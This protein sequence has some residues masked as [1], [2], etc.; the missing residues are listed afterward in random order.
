M[1]RKTVIESDEVS[2][3]KR[4]KQRLTLDSH[5]QKDW[6]LNWGFLVPEGLADE[7]E[8]VRG[9]SA[10]DRL[11]C[12]LDTHKAPKSKYPRAVLSSHEVGWSANLELFG[13]AQH[14][15][16]AIAEELHWSR[17]PWRILADK[18]LGA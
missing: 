4:L 8:L 9:Y 16:V 6:W 3:L 10:K 15:R 2:V 11:Q 12:Q 13:V 7:S 14:K 18:K 17:K 1:E 5:I